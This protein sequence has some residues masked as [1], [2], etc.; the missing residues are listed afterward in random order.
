M[1]VGV[2]GAGA[3]WRKTEWLS[4]FFKAALPKKV[5]QRFLR[6]HLGHAVGNSGA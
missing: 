4:E 2:I 5:Q 3:G 6:L 1:A